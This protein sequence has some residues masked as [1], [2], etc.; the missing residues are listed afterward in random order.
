MAKWEYGWSD[1]EG[2]MADVDGVMKLW[3]E[4]DIMMRRFSSD[5]KY[6]DNN[7]FSSPFSER[8]ELMTWTNMKHTQNF[9]NNYKLFQNELENENRAHFDLLRFSYI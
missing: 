2:G 6:A 9:Q 3:W 7:L 1:W 5:N 8:G 4:R